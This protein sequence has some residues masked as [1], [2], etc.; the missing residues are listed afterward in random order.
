MDTQDRNR[1]KNLT[2]TLSIDLKDVA[3]AGTNGS[4]L[5]GLT[6]DGVVRKLDLNGATL[7]GGLISN[8]TRF[9]VF[10]TSI[11]SYVGTDPADA[12]VAVAGVY[13]DGDETPHVL[14]RVT[15]KEASLFIAVTK[16]YGSDYVALAEGDKV[17]ILKGSYPGSS[18]QD[19]SSLKRFDEVELNAPVTHLS[20]S[21][22][23]AFLLAQAND[24][25]VG[26]EL[27]H[28]RATKGTVSPAGGAAAQPLEW[29]DSAHLWSDDTSSLVM[30]DFDG[31]NAHAIMSVAPGYGASLSQ[32]GRFF[33]GVRVNENTH[34]LQRVRMIL[35]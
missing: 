29:L 34:V 31:T 8:V 10:D 2:R 9:S 18:D 5:Y 21:P 20:F 27:E 17:S 33:Y 15:N 6:V 13:R 7:S 1:D 28:L 30:R 16:Y 23:G 26:Y 19:V 3:F 14:R 22:G 32:N 12:E 11:I 4:T 25:F 24:Q 35:E